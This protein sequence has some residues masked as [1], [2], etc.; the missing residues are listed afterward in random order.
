MQGYLYI[1]ECADGTFYTGSTKNLVIRLEQH[2]SGRG[3][4]YTMKRLPVKLVFY[5]SFTSISD[6][7]YYEKKIQKWSSKKKKALIENKYELLPELSECKN[8]T[9]Y[10]NNMNK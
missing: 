9:N 1:L 4:S 3:A 10:K 6:A 2:R 7:F 8:K 5:E